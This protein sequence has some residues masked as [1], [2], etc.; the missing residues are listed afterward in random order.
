MAKQING[1]GTKP[2]QLPSG[3]WQ[4]RY[5]DPSGRRRSIT[6]PTKTE[7]T[8]AAIQALAAVGNGTWE[9]PAS[10]QQTV[11]EYY[12][13]FISVSKANWKR[14]NLENHQR[15]LKTVNSDLV[16]GK[17]KTMNL[18]KMPIS[19]V[20]P[21]MMDVW[22]NAVRNESVARYEKNGKMAPAGKGHGTA[23][24]AYR[25]VRTVFNFAIRQRIITFNPCNT[26]GAAANS[27][28]RETYA[29]TWDMIPA[30][31]EHLPNRYLAAV[32]IAGA[33]NG[34]RAGEL[35][36]LRR[37][38]IEL[39]TDD[40]G[41]VTGGWVHIRQS[42]W[43]ADDGTWV[44]QEPKTEKSK[45]SSSMPTQVAKIV[46]GH[47]EW[48]VGKDDDDLLFT[49]EKTGVQLGPKTLGRAF[50]RAAT[51]AGYP[52]VSLHSLRRGLVTELLDHDVNQVQVMR[53]VGHTTLQM[54]VHYAKPKA[55]DAEKVG[56]VIEQALAAIGA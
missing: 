36:A 54:M 3:S 27:H 34:G 11:G 49:T 4:V 32:R 1:T 9:P 21:Q 38:D 39:A 45:R 53:A 55:K 5:T 33:V 30:I 35:L 15:V 22:R 16:V 41:E 31:C 18:G 52:E 14:C 28:K 7:A 25:H 48:Y 8:N 6:R 47:L 50:K 29:V 44:Y 19:R 10:E 42:V 20:T 43:F 26:P 24:N 23:A 17:D 46:A 13:H 37:K 40:A 2:T 51:K 12:A 56:N